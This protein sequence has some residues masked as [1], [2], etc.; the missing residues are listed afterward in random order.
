MYKPKLLIV[1]DEINIINAIIRL[2]D[3]DNFDIEYTVE[4]L[5]AIELIKAKEYDLIVSDFKMPGADGL[6]I[7]KLAKEVSPNTVRILMTGYADIKVVIS[8]INDGSIYYFIEKPWENNEFSRVI[9]DAVKSKK[10]DTKEKIIKSLLKIMYIKDMDLYNHSINV[11]NL[12][13]NIAKLL[14]LS[15]TH[16]KAVEVSALLHDVGKLAVR[17]DIL[18]KPDRLDRVEFDHIKKH[19]ERSFAIISEFDILKDAS[20][21]VLQHHE[22]AN[23]TGYPMGL[24]DKDISI[25]AKIISVADSFD[26]LTSNRVYKN[27]VGVKDAMEILINDKNTLYD[28]DI[29]DL[30]SENLEYTLNFKN[31]LQPFIFD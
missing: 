26:A 20:Q 17:D 2:I 9:E 15:E 19:A 11:A 6:E 18:Y 27:A 16:I 4:S 25:E 12:S 21:I 1:D 10:D 31:E 14:N 3:S 13:I 23:G 24:S 5:K 7:L 22:R 29:V 8:A 30:M 28:K